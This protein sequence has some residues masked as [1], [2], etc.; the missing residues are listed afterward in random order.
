M[1]ARAQ[2]PQGRLES[3][4]A[5]R[6]RLCGALRLESATAVLESGTR[7]FAGQPVVEVDLAGVTDADSA[8]LALLI[9]WTR[10]ARAEGRTI[11]FRSLPRRLADMARI[12]GVLELLPILG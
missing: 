8:G 5:G 6:Y 1:R 2:G 10:Q 12:G 9:E 4:S 3:V 11:T 7:Q